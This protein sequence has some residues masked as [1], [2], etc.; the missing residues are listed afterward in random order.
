M[1]LKTDKQ[2]QRA[3]EEDVAALRE[4]LAAEDGRRVPPGRVVVIDSKTGRHLR[5]ATPSE[6]RSYW[7]KQSD[8]RRG[9]DQAVRLNVR[10]TLVLWTGPGSQHWPVRP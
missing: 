7:A 9:F 1:T 6:A 4:R 8:T 2:A 10:N 5:P 3:A